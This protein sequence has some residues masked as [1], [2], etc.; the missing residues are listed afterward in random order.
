MVL[1]YLVK[2]TNLISFRNYLYSLKLDQLALDQPADR[3]RLPDELLAASAAF[4]A[5]PDAL[6]DLLDNFQSKLLI[7]RINVYVQNVTNLKSFDSE[8][9]SSAQ[10][11]DTKLSTLRHRLKGI[12]NP[13]FIKDE[14]Y[15]AIARKLDELNEHH[16]KA[17]FLHFYCYQISK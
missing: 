8:L 15:L 13:F 5:Q 10:E 16:A 4:N 6:P 3:V 2:N 12:T 7:H 17:R 9:T 1:Q 11:A 14:G